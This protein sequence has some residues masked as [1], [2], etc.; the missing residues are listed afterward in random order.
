MGDSTASPA[1]P[2]DSF[3]S[4]RCEHDERSLRRR[5]K[6]NGS[7]CYVM[8]C[9]RCG[10]QVGEEISKGAPIISSLASYPPEW[11]PDLTET[12]WRERVGDGRERWEAM[13]A[14]RAQQAAE[15]WAG[16]DTYLQ[17]DHWQRLRTRRLELDRWQC[18]AMMAGCEG[19]AVQVHHLRYRYVFDEP[20]FDLASV[21]LSCHRRLHAARPETIPIEA[22]R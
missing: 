20:L 12:Y 18:Q 3:V 1:S 6:V 16:Y 19:R 21:C 10:A 5:T 14:Q 4:H 7:T 9:D 22:P 2:P 17:S 13:A 15:W 8:Q 11:D